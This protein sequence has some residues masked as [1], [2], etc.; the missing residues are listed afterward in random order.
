MAFKGKR[1][2]LNTIR[3][4]RIFAGTAN[5]RFYYPSTETS[6]WK[7]KV[8]VDVNDVV[9]VGIMLANT[10][11]LSG[12][13]TGYSLYIEDTNGTDV[14]IS[15]FDNGAG[16][17]LNF[18]LVGAVGSE[19][20]VEVTRSSAGLF[21][22]YVDGD[23]KATITDVTHTTSTYVGVEFEILGD[24][25]DSYV[26]MSKLGSAE[27]NA[28]SASLSFATTP[29][30]TTGTLKVSANN[31]DEMA[32]VNPIIFLLPASSFWSNISTFAAGSPALSTFSNP[33][34]EF[35]ARQNFSFDDMTGFICLGQTEWGTLKT[36]LNKN[37]TVKDSLSDE[38]VVD[39]KLVVKGTILDDFS[40][41]EMK[42]IREETWTLFILDAKQIV[43]LGSYDV[44]DID[45][46]NMY[47]G[48]EF[49]H[50][51]EIYHNVQITISQDGAYNDIP[52][53]EFMVDKIVAN[54][55]S[56]AFDDKYFFLP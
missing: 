14:D 21:T 43:G 54:E 3:E 8:F 4:T 32:N 2:S 52:R 56:E 33:Q 30:S 15:L 31:D 41:E 16:T 19:L 18:T 39:Q 49:I 50:A 34:T 22:V 42:D 13:P 6:Y 24:Y 12:T 26:Q 9:H 44:G 7:F 55:I 17:G 23:S 35:R 1:L 37:L 25:Q 46:N 5:A 40:K 45:I 10:N 29:A 36:E 20:L 27:I 51:I 48:N 53:S 38:I 47:D 28:D 11:L